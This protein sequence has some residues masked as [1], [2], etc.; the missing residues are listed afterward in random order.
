MKLTEI[1]I[2]QP[3][4]SIVFSLVLVVLGVVG[5]SRLELRFFPK[6]ETPLII[7]HIAYE[8]ASANLMESQVTRLVE[9]ALSGL[10]NIQYMTSTSSTSNSYVWIYFLLGGNLKQEAS[11]VRDKVSGIQNQLPSDADPPAITVGTAGANLI[12]LGFTDD[13]KTSADIRDYIEG[14]VSPELRQIKGGGG[15]SVIGASDYAMRIWLD[16]SKMAALNVTVSDVKNA[17][18]ANNIYF[19]AGSFH[20]PTRDYGIIAQTQL[21]NAADFSNIIIRNTSGGTIRLKDVANVELGCR[22]LYVA[23]MRINGK[24][25]VQVVIQP[26]PLANPID[27]ATSIKQELK[28]IQANLP[29]GMHV[30]V[31]YD[32]SLFLKSSVDETFIAIGES[33]ILVM[34]IVFLFL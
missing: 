34:L 1:C 20:G 14:T 26:Q 11:E 6:F 32:I 5:F 3:V 29:P 8:G 12:S 7:V 4:L 28:T 21:K 24:E 27:V 30:Q 22:S 31:N 19:S 10:D 25:G 17:L 23:P 2:K 13:T 33:V 15:V 9:N 16:A 18:T